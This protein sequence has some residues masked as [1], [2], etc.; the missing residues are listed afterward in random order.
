MVKPKTYMLRLYPDKA[1]DKILIDY[2]SRERNIQ[3]YLKHL[4]EKDIEKEKIEVTIRNI[5][6]EYLQKGTVNFHEQNLEQIPDIVKK[7]SSFEN[8][9]IDSQIFE[10]EEIEEDVEQIT[11]EAL[12]FLKGLGQ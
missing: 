6:E 11:P 3:Q 8:Q 5:L 7:E 2:L 12:A 1:S 10:G 4:I 9:D